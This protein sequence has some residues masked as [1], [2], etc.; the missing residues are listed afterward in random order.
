MKN[1]LEFSATYNDSGSFFVTRPDSAS[2]IS[3]GSVYDRHVPYK[4]GTSSFVKAE[5]E[6]LMKEQISEKYNIMFDQLMN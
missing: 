4:T 2:R 5:D 6:R 3:R 1:G